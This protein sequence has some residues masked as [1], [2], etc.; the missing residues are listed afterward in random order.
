MFL[1]KTMGGLISAYTKEAK[2]IKAAQQKVIEDGQKVIADEQVKID[3][4]AK[5]VAMAEAFIANFEEM[6]NPAE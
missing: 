5:E 2:A 1:R 3:V 6:A 4:A